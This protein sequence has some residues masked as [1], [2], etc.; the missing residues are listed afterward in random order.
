MIGLALGGS[1]S[2]DL[3]GTPYLVQRSFNF[4]G[5]LPGPA[6]SALSGNGASISIGSGLYSYL[7]AAYSQG[8]NTQYVVWYIGN[9][10]G[11]I[12]I[13]SELG[14]SLLIGWTLFGPGGQGV[15]DGGTTAMLL[16]TALGALGMARRFLKA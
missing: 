11:D 4:F 10:S 1:Q 5:P 14:N 8:S 6:V 13:P 12:T 9:L 3:G 16:G 15:P 2:V 7:F